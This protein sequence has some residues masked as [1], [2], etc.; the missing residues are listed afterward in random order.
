[1]VLVGVLLAAAAA[2]QAANA[3]AEPPICADRPAKGNAVCTVPAGKVQVETGAIDWSLTK[4]AGARS[5]LTTL[6]SSFVKYGLSDGSD[7]EVGFTPYARL[8]VRDGG[9]RSHVSGFGDVVVRFKHRLTRDGARVQ[10]GIIPFVKVPTAKSG[11]GNDKWEGGLAVPVTFALAGAATMTLGPEL[12]VL[13]DADGNG[14]H[15]ATVQLVNFGLP[16]ADRLSF[17]AELWTNFNFDPAG[18]VRQASADA[19]LAYALS[20][21]AQAD[22]GANFGL[23]RDTADAELYG[24]VSVRF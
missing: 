13:A 15:L 14:H 21:D 2:A 16:V 3:R 20:N 22:V 17:A 7:L 9:S 18:T 8:T 5:E 11:L 1:M 4:A 6:G 24:G 19:A 23:T 12:D 10:A